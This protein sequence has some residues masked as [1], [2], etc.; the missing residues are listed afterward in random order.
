M[1]VKRIHAGV[2]GPTITEAASELGKHL[3]LVTDSLIGHRKLQHGAQ[4]AV[5][6]VFKVQRPAH[7]FAQALDD[8]QA[9]AET[10]FTAHTS[11]R[12]ANKGPA[13]GFAH[14]IRQ[15]GAVVLDGNT[16]SALTAR[17]IDGDIDRRTI[18]AVLGSIGDQVNGDLAQRGRIT[19]N[20]CLL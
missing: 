18:R 1:V 17:V 5:S 6:A 10:V 7:G 19:E 20:N 13:Q 15:P 16:D 4:A 14:I 8:M 11:T 9:Q 12:T 2:S 3:S